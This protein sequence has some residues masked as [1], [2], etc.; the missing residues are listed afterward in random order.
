MAQELLI[1]RASQLV[2]LAGPAR[3][4]VGREMGELGIIEGGAALVRDGVIVA[5]GATS[6]VE[7]LA[8]G[9]A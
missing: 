2:T 4:R 6:E 9:G 8:S 3:P 5:L 7:P 1:T